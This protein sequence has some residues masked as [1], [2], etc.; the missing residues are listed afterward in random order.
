MSSRKIQIYEP[1]EGFNLFKFPGKELSALILIYHVAFLVAPRTPTTKL[2]RSVITRLLIKRVCT[3]DK[4][5]FSNRI[6]VNASW[7]PVP[8]ESFVVFILKSS[9]Y[10]PIHNNVIKIVCNKKYVTELKIILR[11]LWNESIKIYICINWNWILI[12]ILIFFF[13]IRV[14]ITS[15]N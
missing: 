9:K 1:P 8:S 13:L 7:L 6:M 3:A 14:S 2:K 10:P 15:N 11:L 4:R 12:F 5:Q